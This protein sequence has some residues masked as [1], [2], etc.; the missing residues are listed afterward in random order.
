MACDDHVI[1]SGAEAESYAESIIKAAERN[2]GAPRGAHQLALFSA[3]NI[4]ERRIEMILNKDRMRVFTHQWRYLVLFGAMIAAVSVVLISSRHGKIAAQSANNND[5]EQ[6]LIN[7][8][9]EVVE[10]IPQRVNLGKVSPNPNLKL[11]NFISVAGEPMWR[12]LDGFAPRNLTVTRA[13]A[14]DFEVEING[15]KAT[16]EFNGLISFKGPDSIERK[17]ISDRY[18]VGME[19]VNGQWRGLPPPP[20]P[21]PPR[22]ERVEGLDLP[23]PP[24]P[25]PSRLMTVIAGQ[26][27][28][29][30]VRSRSES[31]FDMLR[32]AAAASIRRDTDFYERVL[33]EGF[34]GITPTGEIMNKEQAIADV[35]RMDYTIKKFEFDDLGVSGNVDSAFATFLATVYVETNGQDS[36]A[37]FRYT[38]NFIRRDGQLKIAA[39]HVTQKN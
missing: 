5:D 32:E 36:T 37:Q 22:P 8:V 24:P 11:E 21:P 34:K 39:I 3:R 31:I 14:N 29:P 33:D 16:V 25:P 2:I 13:V 26:E 17:G 27:L 4:L 1:G 10:D 15:D 28:K 38:V 23:P 20:P 9:R 18:T 30:I 7:M 19:K 6:I 12:T 35:K